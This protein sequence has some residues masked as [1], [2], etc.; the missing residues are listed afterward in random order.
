MVGFKLKV[1]RGPG[2]PTVVFR[3]G[4]AGST[5]GS[6]RLLCTCSKKV[7]EVWLIARPLLNHAQAWPDAVQVKVAEADEAVVFEL[8]EH[9]ILGEIRGD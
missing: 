4:T 9:G 7:D 1:W 2:W 8:V 6:R 3:F 5:S